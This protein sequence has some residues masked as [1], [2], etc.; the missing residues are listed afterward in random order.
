MKGTAYETIVS[1]TLKQSYGQFFTPRN[2]IRCMVEM[3]DPDQRYSCLDPAC[4]SGGFLVVLDHV[5]RKMTKNMYPD[6]EGPI[7]DAKYNSP[8][9]DDLVRE[10]ASNMIFG[11]DFDKV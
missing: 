1:N 3:L 7:L 9:I 2:I 10:Y 11:F 8:E 6:L 4:G 5:R